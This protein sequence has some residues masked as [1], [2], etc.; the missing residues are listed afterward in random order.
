MA[1]IVSSRPV[2]VEAQAGNLSAKEASRRLGISPDWLYKQTRAGRLPFAS[3][4]GRRTMFD[5]AGLERWRQKR[6]GRAALGVWVFLPHSRPEVT[7]RGVRGDGF[8]Y[9]R[10]GSWWIQYQLNGE[11]VREPAKIANRDGV[12]QPAK[13]E[14]E[15]LRYLRARRAEVLGGRFIGPKSERLTVDG[16][17]DELDA[18]LTAKRLRS[19]SKV[20]VHMKPVREFFGH[21]RAVDV[22]PS[23][24]ESYKTHRRSEGRA[25][26]T[27]NRELEIL[28]QAYRL[29]V[30]HRRLAPTSAPAIDLLPVDNTR[31]GFF[32]PAEVE[33]ILPHL[34]PDVRDF[35]EWCALTGQRKGE[36]A[37]LTW[38]MLDRGKTW[39]LHIPGAIT[40]NK[41]GRVLPVV[42]SLRTVMERRVSAR[43]LGCELVFHR[44]SK[45]K[46]GQP[47]KAF[48]KAWRNAL[49]E[50]GL[51]VDRLF[52]DLR[53]SA[54]R[55][56]LHAGVSETEAMKV[57]G[58]KTPSMFRRYSIV[59]TAEVEAALLKVD[60][61]KKSHK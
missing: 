58:H 45:G 1:R 37:L 53:R 19:L 2:S 6:T 20:Q 3:R 18:H 11:R 39:T 43:R 4:I 31:E 34:E 50:A 25:D 16:L 41:D 36:A 42:G 30:R 17:L 60:A 28:R 7:M 27:I 32:S 47:V 14:A 52:H 46:A 12:Q 9:P 29:A 23:E 22:E 51:P 35:T 59:S 10:G 24:V 5:A 44:E 13:T 33:R 38:T 26:A 40:K 21:R 49:K 15:A 48:D 61:F 55:N 8:V 56:L 57:T 54:A